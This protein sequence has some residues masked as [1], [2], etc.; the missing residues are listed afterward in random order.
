MSQKCCAMREQEPAHQHNNGEGGWSDARGRAA[1]EP[2]CYRCELLLVPVILL[3]QLL[4]R[5]LRAIM[6]TLVVVMVL[7]LAY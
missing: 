6:S 2:S 1:D 4:A 7:V 3:Q 5:V